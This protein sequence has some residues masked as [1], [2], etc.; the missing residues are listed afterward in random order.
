M[1]VFVAYL[2]ILMLRVDGINVRYIYIINI[3]VILQSARRKV[4]TD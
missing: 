1:S 3:F 4:E 2:L